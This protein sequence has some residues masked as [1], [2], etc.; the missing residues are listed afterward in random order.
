MFPQ[1]ELFWKL[2]H[3]CREIYKRF[4]DYERDGLYEATTSALLESYRNGWCD[5]NEYLEELE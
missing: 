1:D 3:Y 4:Q 5:C 2:V